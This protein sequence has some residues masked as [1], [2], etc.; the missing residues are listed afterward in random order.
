[1]YIIQHIV[2]EDFDMEE[3]YEQQI[4][5]LEIAVPY[6]DRMSAA[7][8]QI[9]KE[10][11]DEKQEDTDEY[12]V[13][14]LNG[15]NWIFSVFNGTQDLINKD[16]VVIDKDIVNESVSMLN[17]GNEAKDDQKRAQAFEGILKFVE[18]FR[19]VAANLSVAG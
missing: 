9:I 4:E 12:I 17:E 16:T 19:E 3:L 15:L 1:M 18:K 10:L 7:L 5:A 6:C 2:L 11:T 13:T 8:K 14:I